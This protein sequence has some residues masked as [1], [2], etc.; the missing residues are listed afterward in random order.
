MILMIGGDGADRYRGSGDETVDGEVV[1]I[2]KRTR[3]Q[4]EKTLYSV[5]VRVEFRVKI[6]KLVVRRHNVCFHHSI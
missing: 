6:A 5:R 1:M 4:T 2:W 3:K